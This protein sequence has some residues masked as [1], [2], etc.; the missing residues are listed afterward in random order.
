MRRVNTLS[1]IGWILSHSPSRTSRECPHW[2]ALSKRLQLT[3]PTTLSALLHCQALNHK[4]CPTSVIPR[5]L[6]LAPLQLALL[7]LGSL[8]DP[9]RCMEDPLPV[10]RYAFGKA[11]PLPDRKPAHPT[12]PVGR[13]SSW[14]DTCCP[15]SPLR[16]RPCRQS[17]PCHDFNHPRVPCAGKHFGAS[18]NMSSGSL[19]SNNLRLCDA[20]GACGNRQ[21]QASPPTMPPAGR[22]ASPDLSE[23]PRNAPLVATPDLAVVLLDSIPAT[24][25]RHT[26]HHAQLTGSSDRSPT[27][28]VLLLR[29][30]SMSWHTSPSLR[31]GGTAQPFLPT[32]TSLPVGLHPESHSRDP[33]TPRCRTNPPVWSPFCRVKLHAWPI[34]TG[35]GATWLLS[36]PT[37]CVGAL[38]DF[39]L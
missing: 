28:I 11:F 8:T 22:G 17:H 21:D 20:L 25:G 19:H 12:R 39:G 35:K 31:Q 32:R 13:F 29:P 3:H 27:L 1:L 18:S 10:H 37:H 9:G 36:T 38:Q 14:L 26:W 5:Q 33:P 34:S 4:A 6:Q 23:T 30:L 24:E 16:R 15:P 7:M 2:R